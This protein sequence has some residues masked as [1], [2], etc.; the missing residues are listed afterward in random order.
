M[1]WLEEAG[2]SEALRETSPLPEFF[3]TNVL[4]SGIFSPFIPTTLAVSMG[5]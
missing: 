5:N 4:E 2:I 3:R 1:K